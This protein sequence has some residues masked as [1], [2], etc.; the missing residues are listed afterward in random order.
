MNLKLY[1]RGGLGNQLYQYSVARYFQK[2]FHFEK[3]EILTNEYKNYKIRNLEIDNFE[4]SDT[5]IIDDKLNIQDSLIKSAYHLFQFIYH[6]LRKRNAPQ[7]SFTIGN[8][9]YVCGMIRIC[10]FGVRKNKDLF[11]YSYLVSADI[12]SKMRDQLMNEIKLKGKRTEGYLSY[13][14][15]I[16]ANKSIA[17]SIRCAKDY[18]DNGWPICSRDFYCNGINKIENRI[19]KC[20][21]YIFADDI[22]KVIN[23]G[24]FNYYHDRSIY[25]NG[26]D[27]CESFELLR[28]CDNYV[29]SNSSFSWWGAF[30]SYG[31]NP[32]IYSPDRVFG[33]TSSD[34][35]VLTKYKG[36]EY[37]NYKTGQ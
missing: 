32:I 35:D 12:A 29:C 2:K 21:I 11:L 13:L 20:N 5:A 31:A 14:S 22:N 28:H 17:V 37:L 8:T 10:S 7:L 9:Q 34:D 3:L 15:D 18:S 26:L 33:N 27:V 19:G 6:N 4:L 30:L 36:V 23:E 16:Q 25:V 24:W 1:L